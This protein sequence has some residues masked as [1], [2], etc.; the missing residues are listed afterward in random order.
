MGNASGLARTRW[1][2]RHWKAACTVICA[3]GIFALGSLAVAVT[4]QGSPT[5]VWAA[6][7]VGGPIAKVCISPNGF[8]A[9]GSLQGDAK[10]WNLSTA[11]VYAYLNR[12]WTLD[13]Q[14]LALGPSAASLAAVG[15]DGKCEF[16][17]CPDGSQIFSQQV[18]N[19]PLR[20]VAVSGDGTKIAVGNDDGHISLLG[21]S[22]S[23]ITSWTAHG[24][25][26]RALVFSADGLYL[27]SAGEDN[28]AKIWTVSSGAVYRT[29]SGH[30]QAVR[31]VAYRA[32]GARLATASD[33]GTVRVWDVSLGTSVLTLTGHAEEVTSV[34]YTPDG[35]RICSG[36]HDGTIRT[37]DAS[38]GHLVATCAATSPSGIVSLAITPD[39]S[40]VVSG[41]SSGDVEY[42]Q[43]ASGQFLR[44]HVGHRSAVSRVTFPPDGTILA[45]GSMDGTTSIRNGATGALVASTANAAIVNPPPFLQAASP[46]IGLNPVADVAITVDHRQIA[47]A[48]WDSAIRLYDASTG[49]LIRSFTGHT[50]SLFAVAITPDAHTL[51]S[52]GND[53]TVRK[54]N[55]D[56]GALLAT[57]TGHTGAV[58]CLAARLEAATPGGGA[59]SPGLPQLA[60][61]VIYSGS[62]D[63]TVRQWKNSG[64]QWQYSAPGT[65]VICLALSPDSSQLAVGCLDNKIRQLDALSG[66]LIREISAHE[67][68]VLSVAYS[69]DGIRIASCSDDRTVR[70]WNAATGASVW[71]DASA[72]AAEVVTI[73][74]GESATAPR[75]GYGHRD[76]TV[77]VLQ[78]Q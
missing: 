17:T 61:V 9:V 72:N 35:S 37:W 21:P 31:A 74:Y 70:T 56:T 47:T 41:R 45:T 2:P 22:G 55:L 42:W 67:A 10:I 18:G 29:L 3:S 14:D 39:G 44:G 66:S 25:G 53:R 30:S 71:V 64:Q 12:G 6:A 59:Q 46:L 27:A 13:I 4:G 20:A 73:S 50:D 65:E 68:P 49:N 16:W 57:Y 38:D 34:A 54:W 78:T 33:D 15:M 48:N 26:V 75:L 28:L 62:E 24:E 8:L 5:L 43:L 76:G 19:V 58:R 7:G 1:W 11:N 77:M 69:P 63:G 32:D 60:K 51:V 40:Q 52:G 36:S 23:I